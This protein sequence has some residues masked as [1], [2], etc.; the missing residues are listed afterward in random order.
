MYYNF[1]Q[2]SIFFFFPYGSLQNFS[3]L[4]SNP[5]FLICLIVFIAQLCII[6]WF[7]SACMSY[8]SRIDYS[9]WNVPSNLP[10]RHNQLVLLLQNTNMD[11][12][13]HLSRFFRVPISTQKNTGVISQGSIK[14]DRSCNKPNAPKL[15]CKHSEVNI[16]QIQK[17]IGN[18]QSDIFSAYWLC[19]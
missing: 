14:H 5:I 10:K 17:S 2:V 11:M 4:H 19:A 1:Y 15:V 7:L 9:K 16:I 13:Q 8:N 12:Q 3:V 18:N 6:Y